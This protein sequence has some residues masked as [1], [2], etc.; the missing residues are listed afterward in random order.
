MTTVTLDLG[1][2]HR[3]QFYRRTIIKDDKPIHLLR[4][5]CTCGWQ[6]IGAPEAVYNAASGHD[7]EPIDV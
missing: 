7:L 6:A 2:I 3:L 5:E 4:G 1:G